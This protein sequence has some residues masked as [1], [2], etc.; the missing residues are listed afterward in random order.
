M[1]HLL[2]LQ[3][4]ILNLLLSSVF[5]IRQKTPYFKSYSP[6][7][8]FG[9]TFLETLDKP[10]PQL[11]LNTFSAS[12]RITTN[13]KISDC[14]KRVLT[15][16]ELWCTNPPCYELHLNSCPDNKVCQLTAN[17][18]G[19]CNN[20]GDDIVLLPGD[21]CTHNTQ[22]RFGLKE[23][24]RSS[25]TSMAKCVSLESAEMCEVTSDCQPGFYC[26]NVFDK[27]ECIKTSDINEPCRDDEVCIGNSLCHY[28][29]FNDKTGICKEF[30]SLDDG[31]YIGMELKIKGSSVFSINHNIV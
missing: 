30:F 21:V 26:H 6:N 11:I 1:N 25:K 18:E 27:K 16:D 15:K 2:T 3:F 4:A 31:T 10:F 23:C 13:R 14:Y 28:E 22:C 29:H 7:Y 20:K 17:G 19:Y 24:K 8:L 9:E 12:Y 5:C